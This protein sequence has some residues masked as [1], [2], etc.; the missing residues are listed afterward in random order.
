[1]SNDVLGIDVKVK[2]TVR[3]G[4]AENTGAAEYLFER[5]VFKV[6]NAQIISASDFAIT[7][8]EDVRKE[9]EAEFRSKRKRAFIKKV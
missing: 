5:K 2:Q 1:M 8:D 7:L 3:R 9:A 6:K 4:P